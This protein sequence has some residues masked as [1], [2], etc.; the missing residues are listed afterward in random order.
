MTPNKPD[1]PNAGISSR[2]NIGHHWPGVGEP[3]RYAMNVMAG[4]ATQP[5]SKATQ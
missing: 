1:A 3:E 4:S 5:P 2:L